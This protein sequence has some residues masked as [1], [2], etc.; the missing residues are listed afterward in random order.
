MNAAARLRMCP[1]GV[2]GGMFKHRVIS[3][4]GINVLSLF[5]VLQEGQ[6]VSKNSLLAI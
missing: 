5:Q 1:G 6:E 2:I 3:I 4:E